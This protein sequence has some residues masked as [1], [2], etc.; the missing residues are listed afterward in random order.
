MIKVWCLFVV[1]LLP[2]DLL[3]LNFAA[4]VGLI[5]ILFGPT[6]LFNVESLTI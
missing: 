1:E 4:A 3:V 2:T 5:L 6:V